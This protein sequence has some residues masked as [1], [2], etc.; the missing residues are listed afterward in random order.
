MFN[1]KDD[2]EYIKRKDIVDAYDTKLKGT[3]HI[4]DV[5]SD[6]RMLLGMTRARKR[7]IEDQLLHQQHVREIAE[8]TGNITILGAVERFVSNPDFIPRYAIDNPIDMDLANRSLESALHIVPI[9]E[10]YVPEIYGEDEVQN[11]YRQEKSFIHVK[12]AM[13]STDNYLITSDRVVFKAIDLD[14]NNNLL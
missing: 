3:A 9:Y 6:K 12:K 4:A 13:L 14:Y 8:Y 10:Q 7:R 1:Y 2:L 5:F 11:M